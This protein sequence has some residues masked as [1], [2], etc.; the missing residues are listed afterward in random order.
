MLG[1]R[2][3]AEIAS[4]S[5][6]RGRVLEVMEVWDGTASGKLLHLLPAFCCDWG[7]WWRP[8]PP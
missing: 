6:L 8:C 7:Q 3:V 1:G 2:K 5:C 4:S